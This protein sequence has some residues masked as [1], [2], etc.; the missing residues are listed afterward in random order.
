MKL[1]THDLWRRWQFPLLVLTAIAPILPSLYCYLLPQAWALSWFFAGVCLVLGCFGMLLEKKVRKIFGYAGFA[2]LLGLGALLLL[3]H[4]EKAYGYL[5]FAAPILYGL[6]LQV[7]LPMADLGQRKEPHAAVFFV[8]VGVYLFWQIFYRVRITSGDPAMEPAEPGIL[9]CFLIFLSLMLLSR[10]R[11]ALSTAAQGR[12]SVPP[13]MQRVNKLLILVFLVGVLLLGTVPF[14]GRVLAAPI[15]WG[16]Q[17]IAALLGLFLNKKPAKPQI[18]SSTNLTQETADWSEVTDATVGTESIRLSEVVT[19]ILFV[20]FLLVVTYFVVRVLVMLVKFL[21]RL[22]RG[23]VR[24]ADGSDGGDYRDEIS[25]VRDTV[26]A[27]TPRSKERKPSAAKKRQMSPNQQIRHRYRVLKQRH[28]KWQASDTV[29]AQLSEEAAA[30]YE[31]TRYGGKDAS[32]EDAKVFA[33]KT[34]GL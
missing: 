23:M 11:S 25:D 3:P 5:L 19:Q 29:R 31:R 15:V 34:R 1:N 10:N 6:A 17:G 13:V 26:S 18:S 9:A 33:E 20:L 24:G 4:T 8:G 28:P 14:I 2:L 12:F 27:L 22:L 21:F 7:I 16:F 30:L 32:P